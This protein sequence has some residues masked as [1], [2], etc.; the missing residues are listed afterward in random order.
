M[1]IEVV[2]LVTMI[3]NVVAMGTSVFLGK[4]NLAIT[5]SLLQAILAFTFPYIVQIR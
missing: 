4:K 5:L 2:L 1:I 3:I